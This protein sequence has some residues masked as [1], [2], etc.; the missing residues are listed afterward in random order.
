MKPW[1]KA[2]IN[3]IQ[4]VIMS[5]KKRKS[6][7]IKILDGDYKTAKEIGIHLVTPTEKEL[8]AAIKDAKGRFVDKIYVYKN[9]VI[10]VNFKL[11]MRNE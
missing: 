3:I 7:E 9:N 8:N 4:E 2:C 10:S 5:F 1:H 6:D 11:K